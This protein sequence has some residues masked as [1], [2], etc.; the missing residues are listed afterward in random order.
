MSP[1]CVF[2]LISMPVIA[3]VLICLWAQTG[4][5]R[6]LIVQAVPVIDAALSDD[7]ISSFNRSTMPASTNSLSQAFNVPSLVARSWIS[8]GCRV[9]L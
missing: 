2:T 6:P 9:H 3:L 8:R 5:V 4:M 1:T 7:A